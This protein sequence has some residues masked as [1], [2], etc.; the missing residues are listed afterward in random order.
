[1]IDKYVGFFENVDNKQFVENFIRMEKWI[2][3]SPDI[4]GETFRE[5]MKYCY[6][7]N[8]L[9]Q[10][11]M[12]V[13]GRRV[14]LAKLTMPLLNIYGKFDHLVP[15]EACEVLTS[16][17]GSRDTEDICLN[18][19]H[20]GIYVSS[21]CQQE[22][23]PKIAQWLKARDEKPAGRAKQTGKGPH[24]ATSRPQARTRAKRGISR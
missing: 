24:S 20:I 9:I 6:Q 23:S 4:P 12:V 10:S 16:K 17:V 14:D 7:Q 11:K 2:F 22:F 1:M 18:T 19:G 13:G 5:F 21:K 8:L 15:P 3:D